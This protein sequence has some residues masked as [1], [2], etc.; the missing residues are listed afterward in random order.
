MLRSVIQF[1]FGVDAA[2]WTNGGSVRFEW[3]RLPR[4]DLAFL[5]L[6]MAALVVVG[7]L[8]LYRREGKNLSRPVRFGLASLRLLAL[9][10]VLGMLLE[11]A[12]VFVKKE[13]NP[14]RVVV[15]VDKSE[16][17][18]LKDAY[19][20]VEKGKKVAAELGLKGIDDLRGVTRTALAEK[21][22]S[23][24]LLAALAQNGDRVV[25]RHDYAGQIIE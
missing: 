12:I 7:V 14:S 21:A 10:G 6:V 4:H 5:L 15:L 13:M 25:G 23:G 9:A 2:E 24:K 20:D 11:P 3:M 22:V 18:D 17:M 19:A 16:S 8:Y 1:L